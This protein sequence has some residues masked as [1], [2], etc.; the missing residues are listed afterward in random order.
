MEGN[1]S[2]TYNRKKNE[3]LVFLYP[4]VICIISSI[5]TRWET[6]FIIQK[7]LKAVT[8]MATATEF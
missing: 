6:P 3:L 8:G 1:N 7:L 5:K 4:T 2:N